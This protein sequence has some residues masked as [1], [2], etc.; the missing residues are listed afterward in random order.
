ML[1]DWSTAM[2]KWQE[3][4]NE[5]GGML[6][7]LGE[8][9]AHFQLL[10]FRIMKNPHP[11]HDLSQEKDTPYMNDLLYLSENTVRKTLVEND[12]LISMTVRLI[13]CCF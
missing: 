1:R 2:L 11:T 6:G 4:L 9:W 3:W 7:I 8:G 12:Q 13:K 5:N 10:R